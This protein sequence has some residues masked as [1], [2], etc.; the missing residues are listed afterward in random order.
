TGVTGWTQFGA[1]AG[2]VQNSYSFNLSSSNEDQTGLSHFRNRH[3]SAEHGRFLQEDPIG[4][5]G[6]L[7]LYAYAGNDPASYTDPFGLNPCFTHPSPKCIHD[8][9]VAAV[10][11]LAQGVNLVGR[12]LREAALSLIPVEK[13]AVAGLGLARSA[14]AGTR[15]NA[16]L[17]FE[18]AT[19]VFARGGGLHPD[20][21]RNATRIIEGT[22]LRNPA[23][24]AELSRGGTN[25]ADWG[26]YT[27][28]TF[29][30]PAGDF[31]VHF[32]YNRA[33]GALNTAIDYKVVLNR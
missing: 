24:I 12:V 7:N 8:S 29:K 10:E 23:V 5:A 1:F 30:S 13:F 21:V 26:K 16:A 33:T 6:G 27:T 32:Y 31:Q 2:A 14:V 3:Y 25:I 28:Q 11:A 20:V 22:D 9:M 18:E 4:F 15:L 17:R 19:S